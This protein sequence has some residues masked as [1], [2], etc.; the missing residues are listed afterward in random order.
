M[1]SFVAAETDTTPG[2]PNDGRRTSHDTSSVA[3]K[4][5]RG[6]AAVDFAPQQMG[7]RQ[8]PR[9]YVHLM[10]MQMASDLRASRR[11]NFIHS[12]RCRRLFWSTDVERRKVVKSCHTRGA[13]LHALCRSVPQSQTIV[14]SLQELGTRSGYDAPQM[15]GALP[16]R[17]IYKMV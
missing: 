9:K 13:H 8:Y 16:S 2:N 7:L 1:I 14:D 11:V 3:E 12:E 15:F 10:C 6:S 4:G 5:Q 17:S